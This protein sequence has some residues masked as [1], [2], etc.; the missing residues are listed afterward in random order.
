MKAGVEPSGMNVIGDRLCILHLIS[1]EMLLHMV[2]RSK[3]LPFIP[4]MPLPPGDSIRNLKRYSAK[5]RL[6]YTNL[7]WI[8]ESS[9][10]FPAQEI[11][12]DV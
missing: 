5:L 7:P 11:S 3:D 4:A 9:F 2:S 10:L 8:W 6:A 1:E 12:G